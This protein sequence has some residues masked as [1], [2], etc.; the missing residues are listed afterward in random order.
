MVP[1][2]G[3]L[4][5]CRAITRV[6]TDFP[7]WT[8]DVVGGRHFEDAPPSDYEK[9]I[10]K[11]VFTVKRQVNL[12]GFQPVQVTKALQSKAAIS[13]VPSLWDEPCG[14]TGLEALAAGSAL[15]TTDRG[16]I[17]EYASGRAVM[18]K[19]SGSERNNQSAEVAFQDAL[20]QELQQL[21]SDDKHR[22]ALQHKAI[23]DFPFTTEN[24]VV[25][26]NKARQVFLSRF[27]NTQL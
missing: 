4:P 2:K 8:L 16:G 21:I 17:P 3:I 26:A 20:A 9:Q 1:E 13:V 18:I 11:A 15:V 7:E 6:L 14:L 19:L 23:N 5:A 10:E 24:M 22:E 27:T 25:N 12:H